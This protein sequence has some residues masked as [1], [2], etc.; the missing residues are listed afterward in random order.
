MYLSSIVGRVVASAAFLLA[1]ALL[2][3]VAARTLLLLC[4][5]LVTGL[6]AALT[7]W[8]ASPLLFASSSFVPLYAAFALCFGGL[9]SLMYPV[10]PPFFPAHVRR[11]LGLLSCLGPASA[12][13]EPQPYGSTGCNLVYQRL[14]PHV[15]YRRLRTLLLCLAAVATLCTRCAAR[16]SA[17]PR[18]RPS[19]AWS[20][21]PS[22]R[23]A[24]PNPP[25]YAWA[26]SSRCSGRPRR[27]R[28]CCSRA[29]AGTARVGTGLCSPRHA[30]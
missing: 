15:E 9:W 18:L 4:L 6:S 7:W 17:S 22:S 16:A 28:C 23:A 13:P 11:S 5:A 14:R 1:T 29:R 24:W 2:G 3:C 20:P 25:C 21:R 12:P 19:S 27:L 26:A 8:V 30:C 10:T